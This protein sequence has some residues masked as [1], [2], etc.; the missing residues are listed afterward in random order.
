MILRDQFT[1]I[2]NLEIT[3]VTNNFLIYKL[4]YKFIIIVTNYFFLKNLSLFI[5]NFLMIR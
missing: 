5:K 1:T 4:L 2:V 3:L